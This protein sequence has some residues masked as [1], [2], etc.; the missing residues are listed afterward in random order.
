[1][2]INVL[3]EVVMVMA[4]I[5]FG[6]IVWWAYAPSRRARFERDAHSVFDDDE[7]DAASR[8]E[9]ARVHRAGKGE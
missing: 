5:A 3:R 6:G 1:M 2:D 8:A 7:R 4:L 9:A